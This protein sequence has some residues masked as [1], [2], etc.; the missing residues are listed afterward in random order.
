MYIHCNSCVLFLALRPWT[1][2][3]LP[4]AS[5]PVSP[6]VLPSG[7]CYRHLKSRN[8]TFT[9]PSFYCLS[10][11]WIIEVPEGFTVKITFYSV[12]TA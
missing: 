4:P 8:S 7:I 6:V 2:S 1:A 9:V 3:K 11:V 12:D 5:P 10:Y